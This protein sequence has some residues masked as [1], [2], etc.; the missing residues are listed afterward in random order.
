MLGQQLFVVR[1][2]G[3]GIV[4]LEVILGQQSFHL[5]RQH[6]AHGNDV[7]LVVQGGLHVVDRNTAAAD[8]RVFHGKLLSLHSPAIDYFL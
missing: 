3:D 8:K 6:V 5:L 7:Q 1:V 4:I 2:A